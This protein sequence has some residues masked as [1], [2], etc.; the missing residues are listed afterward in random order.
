MA[1]HD[2]F[3]G[4][5][6]NRPGHLSFWASVMCTKSVLIKK[7]LPCFILISSIKKTSS[8]ARHLVRSPAFRSLSSV[9]FPHASWE[10]AAKTYISCCQCKGSEF[11]LPLFLQTP[12]PPL[13]IFC[14]P[15]ESHEVSESSSITVCI[16]R[17]SS[18]DLGLCENV[19]AYV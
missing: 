14:L 9:S 18:Q 17:Q 4:W 1:S 10:L 2:T 6:F 3:L 13:S 5:I 8:A 12:C 15:A 19:H 7:R 16:Y 11:F